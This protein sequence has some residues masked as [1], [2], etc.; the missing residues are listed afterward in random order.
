[1]FFLNQISTLESVDLQA[2]I[3][4]FLG[5]AHGKYLLGEEKN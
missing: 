2:A 4:Q 1:V 5:A 3:L